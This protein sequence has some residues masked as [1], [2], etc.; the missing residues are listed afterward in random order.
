MN[1][2]IIYKSKP[3]DIK[4]HCSICNKEVNGFFGLSLHIKKEHRKYYE[5]K[6]G[7]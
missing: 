2:I 6:I 4:I 3:L 1:D 5:I 7:R